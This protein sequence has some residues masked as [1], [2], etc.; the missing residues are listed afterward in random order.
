MNHFIDITYHHDI[1]QHKELHHRLLH[2]KI[3]TVGKKMRHFCLLIL[4]Q[5][6]LANAFTLNSNIHSRG[7]ASLS[8]LS[9][10]NFDDDFNEESSI[11]R[12]GMLAKF[13]SSMSA[14]MA[15]SLGAGGF[16]TE[17]LA[18]PNKIS[19]KYDDRPKRKGPQVRK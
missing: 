11:N 9:A 10:H 15:L 16:P 4:S 6:D 2:Q 5:L 12:R 8:S 7:A 17:A 19:D 13:G 1:F 18:F 14:A 3:N